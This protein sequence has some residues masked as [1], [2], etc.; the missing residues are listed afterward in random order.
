M[1]YWNDSF[2]WKWQFLHCLRH[3]KTAYRW[4]NRCTGM[5][6]SQQT[7]RSKHLLWGSFCFNMKEI[8]HSRMLVQLHLNLQRFKLYLLKFKKR[9]HTCMSYYPV[10]FKVTL[11]ERLHSIFSEIVLGI[12]DNLVPA[13]KS[14]RGI[15]V[16][17]KYL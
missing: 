12:Q 7:T 8:P 6:L 9:M 4:R 10:W 14:I 5:Q 1:R 13:L 17:N 11:K 16:H 2:I 3:L 15:Y